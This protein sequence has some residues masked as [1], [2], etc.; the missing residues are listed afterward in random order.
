MFSTLKASWSDFISISLNDDNAKCVYNNR[1]CSSVPG[2]LR[3]IS[4]NKITSKI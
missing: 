3:H 1:H 4:I 2:Q